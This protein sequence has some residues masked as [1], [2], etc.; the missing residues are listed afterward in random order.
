MWGSKQQARNADEWR[1]RWDL[2]VDVDSLSLLMRCR[3][4]P[5]VIELLLWLTVGWPWLVNRAVR[6]GRSLRLLSNVYFCGVV[7]ND[8]RLDLSNYR[9]RRQSLLHN[10][11]GSVASCYKSHRLPTSLRPLYY[12]VL[13]KRRDLETGGK[14]R[15]MSLKMAPFDLY[16]F[17]LIGSCKDGCMLYHFQV[18]WRWIIVTLKR[19]RKV[20]Q[21]GTIRKLGCG[22][23]YSL[24]IVIM[25]VSLTV[26]DIFNVKL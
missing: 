5:L 23:L 16:D 18:I 12:V 25:A 10:I 8:K 26:H 13:L 11:T 6:P 1:K 3:R 17:L 9:V 7:D 24:P 15:S 19:S 22:F 2:T 14:G 4:V 20:I 21:T